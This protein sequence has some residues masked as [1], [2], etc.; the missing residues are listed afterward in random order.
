MAEHGP[1]QASAE[2]QPSSITRDKTVLDLWLLLDAHPCR[3]G[4]GDALR[5]LQRCA[6]VVQ[7]CGDVVQRVAGLL[8]RHSAIQ[9][10]AGHDAAP[11]MRRASVAAT[12]T[13]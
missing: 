4:R 6:H 8:R 13:A 5:S 3:C 12:A 1:C 2:T 10:L 11:L 7:S 9:P